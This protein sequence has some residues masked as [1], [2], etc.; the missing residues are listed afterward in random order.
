MR[1]LWEPV[2]EPADAA[3]FHVYRSGPDVAEAQRLTDM[4][5]P[6]TAACYDDR[7]PQDGVYRYAVTALDRSGWESPRSHLAEAVWGR[8]AAPPRIVAVQPPSMLQ[9]GSEFVLRVAVLSQSPVSEVNLH[10]RV[11]PASPWRRVR[12]QH[13]FGRSWEG[14]IPGSE[15]AAGNLLFYV[16]ATDDTGTA[17]QWPATAGQGRPWI[18]TVTGKRPSRGG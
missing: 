11:S 7:P 1:L 10:H 2:S 4:P 9:A 17:S 14:R 3:G 13:R 18:A 16:Q 15:L 5:L 12:M 8:R 6:P